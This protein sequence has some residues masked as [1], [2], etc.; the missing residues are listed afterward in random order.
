VSGAPSFAS[1]NRFAC[2][3]HK[4]NKVDSAVE[5]RDAPPASKRLPEP[6]ELPKPPVILRVRRPGWERKL[7]KRYTVAA[8]PGSNSLHLPVEIESVDN[9]VKLSLK[10]LV[11][12]GATSEFIDKEYAI[13]TRIPL[14][15]LSQPIPVFN[16]DGSPNE[17]GA[18]S[19]VADVVLRYKGH[20]ERVQFAV[21]R[22][23]KQKLILGY[24]WLR[25]HNPEIDWETRDV[26]MTR[27]PA[28]CATCRDEVRKE[29]R[30]ARVV[31]RILRSVRA[32]PFPSI[33]VVD[34]DDREGEDHEDDDDPDLPGLIPDS[35]DDSD[36]E[37]NPIEDGDRIFYTRFGP[38]EDIR[39]TS[40][41]SQRLAEAHAKNSG[42][43]PTEVP[44]WIREF[45][46]V[47][48][49][50]SFDSLP[51][52]RTW[53]HAIELV[54]DSKP[55]NCKV[56][57]ISPVEQ[58]ELDAF[59]EEGLATGRIRPSKSPM[60]SPVFFV[61]KK[62]GA[63]RFV[64][65]YRALNAMTV[66]NRYPL[67]LINDLINRLKGARYFTK[68]DVRWGF[69]N[70]RIRE[71][72]EWKAAF[73]TNRGLFEP[74]VMYF[75]LTNSPAT[76]QTMM[77][78]IFRDLIL[79]G[80]VMVYLDDILIAHSDLARH[81]KIV[82]EVLRRLRAHKLYLR[83][84]KCEFEKASI[85]YLGVIISHNHVEMDPVKVAGVAAWPTPGNKKDVQQFLGFTNFYRRF[86]RG[87]SDIARP[88][89]DL[90]K[91]GMRWSWGSS[92]DAAFQ[93]LKDAVTSDPVLILPD[94]S[95]PY[96]LEA[97]SSDFATG[98]VLSQPD[99]D[100]KWHPVAFFS[101][102]LNEVQRNYEIHDKEMLA[103]IRALEEW[104]HFLEGTEH[105]VEIWTDHKNLEY[106]REARTLNRRQA[107]WSL[108][109]S[110]FDFALHHKPGSSMGRP[111]ALSRRPDHGGS[112]EDNRDVT[113]LRP[114]LFHVRA[115]EGVVVSGPEV[116]I[117]R[118][119][120]NALSREAD[121]EDPVARAAREVLKVR[122][123]RSTRSSE[124][125]VEGGLLYFRG[126][127][128]VPRDSDLRRRIMEQHHDTRVAGHAGRFK[129]LE[130]VSR[131][132]WWP[133]M[134]RH[135]G[136]YV[137]TCDLCCRT[138]ALRKLPIG[139]LHPTEVPPER[140]HTVSV[141]FIV[142]LPEAHGYNAIMVAADV[143]GK[144][145]HFIECHTQIDAVGSARL[146]YRNV[147]R[148]HGTPV[149]YISDR[150]PQFVAEFTR[151]LFR[152]I[153]IQPAT[154]T[155]Y[156]PQTD[157]QTERINQELDQFIR[158]FTNYKQDDWDELLPA[159]EFAYN[160]HIH[161]ST[162]QVPFMTDTG[163]L[164]RMGFEPNGPRS[165]LEDVNDFRDR[166]AS[167]VS[168]AQAALVKAKDEYKR[169]YDR[170]RTP[171]PEIKV[172]DRVWLDASDIH[173][174][175][176]SPGLSHRRLGPFR[177]SEVI[178]RGAFKLDL[179]PRLSRLHPVFPVVKLELAEHDPFGG[180]PGYDEPPPVLADGADSEWEV[181]EVLD[182]KM[183]YRSLW[184]FVRF[185][186]YDNSHDQWVKHSDVFAPD[187]IAEFYRKYPGK[188][189]AIAATTFDALPFQ[190][191]ATSSAHIRA[192]RRGAAFQ[193]GGDVRGT[194]VSNLRTSDPTSGRTSGTSAI[195]RRPPRQAKPH[196]G[197]SPH[198]R[199]HSACDRA[200]DHCRSLRHQRTMRNP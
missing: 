96:R 80:D 4:S 91:K 75:G 37:D 59:I 117:L 100:G 13:S 109:L 72:D 67:P 113:L 57:P 27:C 182:A 153:G 68:L 46:D 157:G 147:W 175:R 200:R 84:E 116:P 102:S 173:T 85:E 181:E 118:D 10:G 120:R 123:T 49:R 119:I 111:D 141:D 143:L 29:R 48:N 17:A 19:E 47:F 58:K 26:K 28:S 136:R 14:R 93:A 81:R 114:E 165:R 140:W 132:Y 150:G 187:A 124:W 126:K 69:N 44:D 166:I 134:S 7:P 65:D 39:A 142:E 6:P 163:R 32:G 36:D 169:Y 106:F 190:D 45:E 55:A 151:E 146:Y 139:E 51:E 21:T 66:K 53:D 3:Y 9:A 87:F 83:P 108:Y 160:N 99:A 40:T 167:G 63:L 174:T 185:K 35:E 2:L 90:T 34:T 130:L 22:L 23:G 56:Y 60:A 125:H 8:T 52:R 161:S 89:F 194:P 95:K 31:A 149:R 170:R 154:S 186:G 135:V 101:K 73:R 79:S 168:E 138:K 122:G 177:V 12:C 198:S 61:K 62:D 18:I 11:D 131:N 197:G 54:P 164:P 110:R 191:P 94:P 162:Q 158:L 127:I 92:E 171:A 70:V 195:L 50:E 77:N 137:A 97:D 176:P 105:P 144:R 74:L 121:L 98:A 30:E 5:T 16:V 25:K 76:F 179:P 103:I 82:S 148:H 71:G 38:S 88:L 41:V 196:S 104:R 152:L 193:G 42:P 184:Y 1:S 183:R 178:G 192:M 189:R 128:V 180:R 64:Q 172:G 107:R 86:V 33:C 43:P 112:S 155:A 78:D 15:K 20:S 24:S 156:H 199:W 129:T 188:P 145:A 115:M 159:A 133:Q